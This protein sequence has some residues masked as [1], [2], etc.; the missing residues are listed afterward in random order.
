LPPEHAVGIYR[1]V[2]EAL[3]NVARHASATHVHVKLSF[4]ENRLSVSVRDDG[5][6]INQEEQLRRNAFGLT[7]MRERAQLLGGFLAVTAHSDGGTNVCL[8][9]PLPAQHETAEA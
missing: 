1:V 7:T 6:G 5:R 4:E 8:E 3:T 2:E 9:L